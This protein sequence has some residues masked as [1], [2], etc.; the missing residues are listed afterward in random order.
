MDNKTIS[1]N[2]INFLGHKNK[3]KDDYFI[4]LLSDTPDFIGEDGQPYGPF[5]K[6]QIVEVPLGWQR[7][8]NILVERGLARKYINF[9]SPK[10]L[11]DWAIYYHSLGFNVIPIKSKGE[12]KDDYKKPFFEWKPYQTKRVTIEE[13]NKWWDKWPTANIGLICGGISGFAVLDIDVDKGG[14]ESLQK[15]APEDFRPEDLTTPT[16]KTGR[17]GGGLHFYFKCNKP[18]N[19][20]TDLMPGVDWQGEGSYVIAPP[21]VHFTG[22]YYSWE[23]SL[24]LGMIEI[25][26]WVNKAINNYKKGKSNGQ[27]RQDNDKTSL[28]TR[29]RRN[30]ELTSLSGDLYNKGYNPDNIKKVLHAVNKEI[31]EEPLP[32]REVD[33]IR[34]SWPKRKF[35]DNDV[36]NAERMVYYF[37]DKFLY[38]PPEDQFYIWDGR[39]WAKDDMDVIW[40]LA[41]ETVKNIAKIEIENLDGEAAKEMLG[42]AKSSFSNVKMRGMINCLKTQ[43][44]VKVSPEYFDKNPDLLCCNNGVLDLNTFDFREHRQEDYLTKIIELDYDPDATHG[45]WDNYINRALPNDKVRGFVQ[46]VAGLCL[47]GRLLEQKFFNIYGPPDCGKSRFA[48]AMLGVLGEGIYGHTADFSTFEKNKRVGGQARPDLM[49]LDGKRIV[50]VHEVP[51]DGK[52]LDESL[53]K[54]MTGG[55][56][57]TQ[58]TLFKENETFQAKGTLIFFGNHKI[59]YSG[60]ELSMIKR[61]IFIPFDNPV[62]INEQDN[63]L[64]EKLK[65]WPDVRRAVLKWMVDGLKMY[66]ADIEKNNKLT[67]PKEVQELTEKSNLENDP[68]GSFIN[69]ACEVKESNVI[70]AK[71]LYDIFLKYCEEQDIS[72]ISKKKFGNIIAE[73][74]FE[75]DMSKRPILYLGL[76]INPIWLEAWQKKDEND[77]K[78]NTKKEEEPEIEAIEEE[79]ND[80]EG[81]DVYQ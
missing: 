8:A 62:P 73:K 61:A 10:T 76:S 56:D 50:I 59:R 33:A 48:D 17:D 39:H 75:K 68:V 28:I 65:D 44:E 42:W 77:A 71:T 47:T 27:I 1:A 45:V 22:R 38:C 54:S 35:L 24:S 19:K 51:E 26:D 21:S 41:R 14:L 69:D 34:T 67:I 37:G 52:R 66:Y 79:I 20:I 32:E 58:R 16:V 11:K 70:D 81:L 43:T 74:G 12:T 49:Q 23:K 13:I 5:K 78:D 29:G 6:G 55:D 80:Q 9:E 2:Q 72:N 15:I 31:T 40:E 30:V 7:N 63:K 18:Q 4:E 3:A 57:L 25:P 46:T 53:V 64:P 60:H 36:G